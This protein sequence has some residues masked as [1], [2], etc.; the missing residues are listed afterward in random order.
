[1]KRVKEFLQKQWDGE[2]PLLLGYSGGPDSK[3]LLYALIEEKCHCLHVAHVDHGWREESSNEAK[4]IRQEIEDLKLPFYSIRLSM[5]L[6]GGNKEA[7]ARNQR[8]AF[9]RS[10]FEKIPFQALILGHHA[11]DLAETALKRVLE[12]AHLPLL[13][14]IESVSILDEIPVWRPLLKIK[15][16]DLVAFLENR[17]LKPFFDATNQDL[18]YL[19]SRMRMETLPFLHKS[20]GKSI[21]DN[22]CLLSER[23]QELKRYLDQ[24]IAHCEVKKMDWGCAVSCRGLER[25]EQRHLLQKIALQENLTLTRSVLEPVLDW[26]DGQQE[27]KK[28]YFQSKWI[29][30]GRGWVFFLNSD[31]NRS[32]NHLKEV[33]RIGSKR[34]STK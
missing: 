12:G 10:L 22:L 33:Y 25:I 26:I 20:F 1:M 14:G 18:F 29:V 23:S 3:A 11:D 2:S 34:V 19:R 5:S 28:I 6:T 27:R 21:M 17:G 16:K 13:G 31:E 15:K 4:L 9:F 24:K 32:L 7:E 8:F 30:S